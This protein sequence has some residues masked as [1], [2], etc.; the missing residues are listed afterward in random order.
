MIK[1]IC[2]ALLLVGIG[3]SGLAQESPAPSV[4]IP[5]MASDSHHR[6]V[7]VTVESLVITDQKTPVAGASLVR[8][9][10]LPVELGVLIDTSASQRS[11]DL[12]GVL[13]VAKQFMSEIIQGP[14]DRVFILKFEAAPDATE[15]LTREQLPSTAVQVKIG[16]GTALYD[17]LVMACKERMGPRNWQKPT[18]R[19]LV[20][21]SDGDDNLSHATRD[22]AASDALR[23]GAVIFAI[24]TDPS[25]M[26]MSYRGAKILQSL[27]DVTGGEFF[28]PD[29]P[30]RR[31]KSF[32]EHQGN[33]RG[34]VLPKI[35][36][37]QC[38]K[39]RGP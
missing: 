17:A 33:D 9:A 16:G 36:A 28:N 32:H 27:A 29:K 12:T 26:T 35:C 11:K 18:R 34:D 19:I 31:D 6:P 2:K 22:E 3:A 15:W 38:I 30:Q 37:A 8:G 23:A 10:D 21:V 39:S 4:A 24:D 1:L 7:S 25:G 13:N 20:L 5:L 14:E